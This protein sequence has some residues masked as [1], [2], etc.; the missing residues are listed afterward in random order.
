[1]S[2]TERL[3]EPSGEASLL[4]Q[5]PVPECQFMTMMSFRFFSVNVGFM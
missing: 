1:M 3:L 5:N 4:D 2:R